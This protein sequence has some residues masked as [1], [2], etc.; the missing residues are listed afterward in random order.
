MQLE[1]FDESPK[2]RWALTFTI[3]FNHSNAD[4]EEI[5]P[6]VYLA[7][8]AICIIVN[9]QFFFLCISPQHTVP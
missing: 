5:R 4:N 9:T 8:G 6:V 3:F 2:Q 7:N 1:K